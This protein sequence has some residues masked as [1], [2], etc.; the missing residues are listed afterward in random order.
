MFRILKIS[1]KVETYDNFILNKIK[2][3]YEK[4]WSWDKFSKED[5][6]SVCKITDYELFS[7]CKDEI[8]ISYVG[9]VKAKYFFICCVRKENIDIQDIWKFYLFVLEHNL[10]GYCILMVN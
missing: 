7:K 2:A 6:L 10:N 5:L 8:T 1:F 9:L 4:I 3:N